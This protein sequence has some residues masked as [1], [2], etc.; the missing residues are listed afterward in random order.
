MSSSTAT[1][2]A[3][4]NAEAGLRFLFEKKAD[5]MELFLP[6]AAAVVLERALGNKE[7][8][9]VVVVDADGNA[10]TCSAVGS[11]GACSSRSSYSRAITAIHLRKQKKVTIMR[12]LWE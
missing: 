7:S 8:A 2:A 10:A 11:S 5:D 9:V 1:A 4:F 12:N 3:A 6:A